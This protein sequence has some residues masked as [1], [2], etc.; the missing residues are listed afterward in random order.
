MSTTAHL[1]KRL[2]KSLEYEGINNAR[3]VVWDD[4]LTGFGVRVYPSGLK[5]YVLLFRIEG[6]QR[7]FTIGKCESLTLAQ[8]RKRATKH[9]VGIGEG[10]DPL[11]DRTARAQAPTVKALCNMYK[12][13]HPG[14]ERKSW[15][16]NQSRIDR[17]LSA[18]ANHKVVNISTADISVLHRRVGAAT[19]YEANRL[20]ALLSKMFS[21][22]EQWGFV[23]PGH[24]N[25]CRGIKKYP[26]QSRDRWVTPE[27]M[28]RLAKAIECEKD[29]Y[30]QA[31]I[32]LYIFT[33][34][35]KSEVL[36]LKWTNVDLLANQITLSGENTKSGRSLYL[37]MSKP[38]IDIFH[39]LT[40]REGNPHVLPGRIQGSHLIN[41]NKA[42]GRIKTKAKLEDVRLHDLRRTVGSMLAQSGASLHLIGK[43]LNHANTSTTAIYAHFAQDQVREALD[44]HGEAILKLIDHDHGS[45]IDV[46]VDK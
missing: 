45:L 40:R 29:L 1:T 14:D 20:L 6:R 17:H 10:S 34:M 32:W 25:P 44:N 35:R 23:P 19:P 16:E 38:V 11:N 26:E 7:Q 30:V 15:K 37:P 33:G 31:A 27:E 4:K 36:S 42:W 39:A 3:Y 12:Q 13:D 5:A 8:A 24:V 22:A 18:W 41:I 46:G 28:P 9:L 43:V 2:I 21:L